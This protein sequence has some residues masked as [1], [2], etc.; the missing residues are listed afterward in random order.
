VRLGRFGNLKK[1][2]SDRGASPEELDLPESSQGTHAWLSLGIQRKTSDN[3]NHVNCSGD[4]GQG[5]GILRSVSSTAHPDSS[6]AA[7]L[8]RC[9]PPDRGLAETEGLADGE[10]DTSIPLGPRAAEE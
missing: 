5:G 3:E 10:K 7:G 2:Y 4:L 1:R 6:Q 9:S 8:L